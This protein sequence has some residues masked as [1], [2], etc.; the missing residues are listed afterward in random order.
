MATARPRMDILGEL[1]GDVLL[2]P[3]ALNRALEANDRLKYCFD[4]LS[5]AERHALEPEAEL[6]SLRSEREANGID[7]ADL[8]HVVA[9]TCRENGHYVIPHAERVHRLLV[10]CIDDMIAP[11]VAA[12]PSGEVTPAVNYRDRLRSILCCLPP[13]T[14]ERVDPRYVSVATRAEP[15][16]GDTVHRL[17]SDLARELGRL[18]ESLS[19]ESI[20]GAQVYGIGADDRIL[21][22]AFMAG[23]NETAGLKFDHPGLGTTA[24]RTGAVLLLHNEIAGSDA[25]LLRIGVEGLGCTITHADPHV[26]R[27]RFFQALIAGFG[28]EWTEGHARDV[29]SREEGAYHLY[30]GRF[31]PR[32]RAQLES[33]LTVLGSRLVFL[34]DWNRARKRLRNFV[35]GSGCIEVLRWAADQHHGHCAFLQLGAER[36][37]YQAVEQATPSPIRYGQR[38]DEVLGREQTIA[39]LEAVLRITSDGLRHGRSERFIRDEIRAELAGRFETVE[40]GIL[41]IAAQHA[42]CV[43]RIAGL[44]REAL[45][46]GGEMASLVAANA[47]AASRGEREA[48]ELVD[49]GRNLAQ[50]SQGT[51]V[52]A[53][54]LGGA[55]DSADALEDAAFLLTLLPS[56]PPVSSLGRPFEHLSSLLVS[57]AEEWGHC[58]AAATQVR[59]R[60]A[61]EGLQEFL[62]SVDR[63]AVLEDQIDGAERSVIAALFGGPTEPRALQLLLLVSQALEHAADALAHAALALRDHLLEEVTSR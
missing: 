5:L 53:R 28:L 9:G 23:I 24:T 52:Y 13:V 29:R 62:G 44:V 58:L 40:H 25:H 56:A 10:D 51:Q 14:G 61:R 16:G 2:L 19:R 50:S 21:V 6:P 36:L 32:D 37:V 35:D 26:Q 45:I 63:I 43:A 48:D 8:D 60:G 31:A 3:D 46:A 4:L 49:R 1:G 33:F 12:W 22:R 38:L 34:I 18:Q 17:A 27:A 7:D 54:L 57:A 39:F 20:E 11:L 30:S 55:D 42:A 41:S 15:G 47:A 59:K